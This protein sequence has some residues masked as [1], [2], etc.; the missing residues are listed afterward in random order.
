MAAVRRR[1]VLV[2]ADPATSPIAFDYTGPRGANC[3]SL[4]SFV[5]RMVGCKDLEVAVV[6]KNAVV[7]VLEDYDLLSDRGD[8]YVY[9]VVGAGHKLTAIF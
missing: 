2:Y 8:S 9:E 7:R 3:W 1:V 5:Q 4:K 6:V